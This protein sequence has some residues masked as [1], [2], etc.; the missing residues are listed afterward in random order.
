VPSSVFAC[1]L[2]K[3]RGKYGCLFQN[4]QRALTELSRDLDGCDDGDEKVM[5]EAMTK[6]Q[7]I[8]PA[9]DPGIETY[10]C[11]RAK[12]RGRG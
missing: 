2:I 12:T 3:E 10:F 5:P 9:R 11:R 1:D 4:L 6:H 7:K 8:A